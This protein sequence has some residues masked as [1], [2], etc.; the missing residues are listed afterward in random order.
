MISVVVVVAGAGRDRV[1]ARRQ[2]ARLTG[3]TFARLLLFRHIL[4]LVCLRPH[5][6][7]HSFGGL[8]CVNVGDAALGLGNLGQCEDGLEGLSLSLGRVATTKPK[9]VARLNACS[10]DCRCLV[11]K[12]DNFFQFDDWSLSTGRL[13]FGDQCL[14]FERT[15]AHV[16]VP[17]LLDKQVCLLGLAFSI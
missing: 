11:F 14:R 4:I 15:V 9:Q 10:A 6:V 3:F 12:L 1:H 13:G 2:L 8:V 17:Q 5:N 16:L 7:G